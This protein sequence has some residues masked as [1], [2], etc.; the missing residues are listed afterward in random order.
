MQR[1]EFL[2]ASAAAATLGL[3]G[4]SA[5]AAGDAGGR[6][7][8]ELRVYHFATEEKLKAFSKFMAEA[9][10]A[11]LNRAG[12][13]PVGMFTLHAKDN[14]ALK[15]TSDPLDSAAGRAVFRNELL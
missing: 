6:Q 1:R 10:V 13:S 3:M 12:V 14:A 11:A 8:Y 4:T 15:L 5:S 7:L 9:A 2:A